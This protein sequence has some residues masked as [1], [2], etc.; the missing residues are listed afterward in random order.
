MS[1]IEDAA[2]EVLTAFI[3]EIVKAMVDRPQDVIVRARSKPSFLM[4][5]V[6]VHVS[7]VGKVLGRNHASFHALT[8]ILIAAA[9]KL[10][11]SARLH[12]VEPSRLK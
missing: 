4:L 12:V 10:R 7:D 5:D 3:Q 2:A 8:T 1:Q 9:G 11:M 6:Y